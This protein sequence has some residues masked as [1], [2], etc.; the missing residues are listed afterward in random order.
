MTINPIIMVTK[1]LLIKNKYNF[2]E[3]VRQC[4]YIPSLTEKGKKN[5]QNVRQNDFTF[6]DSFS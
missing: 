3:N 6:K 1:F 4:K 2:K 5:L